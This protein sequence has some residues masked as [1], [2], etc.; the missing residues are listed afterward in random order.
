MPQPKLQY[1][2]PSEFRSWWDDMSARHIV[3]MDTFRHQLGSRV[4]IS[5]AEGALGRNLGPNNESTHNVDYW[6][7]VLATD[8]FVEHV[9][10]RPQANAVYQL[11]KDIGFTGIGVYPQWANNS[12]KLQVG[13]H[14]DSRPTRQMGDPA[15]WGR[16]NGEY[17]AIE[18]A[19]Q[20]IPLK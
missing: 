15:T 11:A 12:G 20:R 10:F 1:Y 18:N 14:L 17:I 7:E 13:F 5:A 2:V 8:I 3:L 16:V 6:G 19:L 9:H 4:F